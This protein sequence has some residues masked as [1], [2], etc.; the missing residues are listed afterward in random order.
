MILIELMNYANNYTNKS[1]EKLRRPR[2]IINLIYKLNCL[3]HPSILR[4]EC[5]I[6]KT[7]YPS[8]IPRQ[9]QSSLGDRIELKIDG[10]R[11]VKYYRSMKTRNL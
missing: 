4:Q 7:M 6:D 5:L 2:Q 9:G 11:Q 8:S 10:K 3:E 1:L